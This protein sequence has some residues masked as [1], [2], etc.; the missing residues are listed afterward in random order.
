MRQNFGHNKR[1][2]EEAKKARQEQKRNKK[3]NKKSENLPPPESE[4]APENGGL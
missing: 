4:P 1:K 3:L 2:I